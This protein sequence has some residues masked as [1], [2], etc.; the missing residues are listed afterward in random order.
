M[1]PRTF[2]SF[3]W[4]G[5]EAGSQKPGCTHTEDSM[6][7]A[8]SWSNIAHFIDLYCI[9]HNKQAIEFRQEGNVHKAHTQE[10][11]IEQSASKYINLTL[12]WFHTSCSS[13]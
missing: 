7:K 11:T 8:Q 13:N 9:N 10:M 6:I 4:K 3:C 5:L 1:K 2:F 12:N